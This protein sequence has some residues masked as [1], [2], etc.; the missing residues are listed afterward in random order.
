MPGAGGMVNDSP[1]RALRYAPCPTEGAGAVK[2]PQRHPTTA[3]TAG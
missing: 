1:S 3:Q 2:E